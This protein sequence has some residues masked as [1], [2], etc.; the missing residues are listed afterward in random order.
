MA[1]ILEP[2]RDLCEQV[3]RLLIR[4]FIR[5]FIRRLIRRYLGARV[6]RPVQRSLPISITHSWIVRRRYRRG[7]AGAPEIRPR[8][9]RDA[10]E[11]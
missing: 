6:R 8:Y 11:I 10:P 2:A 1:L 5:R 4:R 3:I 9:V 7:G